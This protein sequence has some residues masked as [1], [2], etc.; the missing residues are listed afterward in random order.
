MRT[1]IFIIG[2]I[3]AAIAIGFIG[4]RKYTKSFS[5]AAT[6]T[7]TSKNLNINVSYCQPFKKGRTIFGNA[8]G[9]LV[10]FGVV[11]RTGANEATEIEFDRDLKFEGELLKKGRY[12]L[13]TI[14]GEKSWIIIFNN[15]LGQW[16]AFDYDQS[17]D[18]LRIQAFPKASPRPNEQFIISFS[19]DANG[20]GM[21]FDWD[22]IATRVNIELP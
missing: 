8:A 17:K 15:D 12:A 19:E 1:V 6:A 3:I 10:P 20:L 13:F 18:A 14:P 5:P 7:Y 21:N 11:W 16:G 9:A 2:I 4:T 22:N